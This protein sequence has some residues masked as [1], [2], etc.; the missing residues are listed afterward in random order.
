MIL[1][2]FIIVRRIISYIFVFF[3]RRFIIRLIRRGRRR[4]TQEEDGD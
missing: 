3:D 4:V 1:F 2:D